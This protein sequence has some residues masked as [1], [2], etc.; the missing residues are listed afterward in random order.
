M[1]DPWVLDEID[2]VAGKLGKARA[3]L[4]VVEVMARVSARHC[5]EED[6]REA[7]N[8]I[9]ALALKALEETD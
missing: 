8:N 6:A 2:T 5:A 4:R 7:F 9:A 3:N 1:T